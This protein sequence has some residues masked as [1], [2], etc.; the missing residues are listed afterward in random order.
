MAFSENGLDPNGS[1]S[2]GIGVLGAYQS[3]A[4]N[5]STIVADG[6]FD[7]HATVFKDGQ[8]LWV[9]GSTGGNLY[10]ITV[11]G[12]TDVSLNLRVTTG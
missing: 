11:S 8:L 12:T 1:G 4:D 5:L 3:T 10:D 6:Y 2:K 7:S 9:F